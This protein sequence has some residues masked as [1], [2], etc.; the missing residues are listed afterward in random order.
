M[1]ITGLIPEPQSTSNEWAERCGYWQRKSDERPNKRKRREKETRGLILAGHGISIAVHRGTLLIQDGNTHF[2]SQK[3]THRLFKGDLNNPPRIVL[4]DGSGNV[5]L[6]AIDWLA[7]QKVDL[8]RLKWDGRISSVASASG[9]S[10]NP[11]R[12]A[13]QLATRQNASKRMTFAVGQ[14]T[15]KI[16]G[17]LF[18]LENLLPPS[19]SR[20]KAI[21]TAKSALKELKNR[22]PQSIGKLLAIEGAV[23]AGYFF[24][25]RAISL[26]WKSTTRYPIPDEWRRYFSRSSLKHLKTPGN[27]A[28]THPIN[29]MLNYAY[30]ILEA[31]VRM[32][33][34]A[35]GYDPSIGILHDRISPDRHSF[36]FDLIEPLRPPIDRIIL[37]LITL[38]E[39][40]G[41]D[42]I[43][44]RHGV[45][46]L[47]PNLAR[48]I[49]RECEKQEYSLTEIGKP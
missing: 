33:T 27:S 44:Q 45:C 9:Y 10:A 35:Q 42:F 37:K 32:Q 40:C 15:D 39:F 12:L 38:E 36:V 7:E 1:D 31:Q 21:E 48:K 34:I 6:D 3:R 20:E 47:M 49:V 24:A 28:A 19:H 43:L 4:V 30:G 11:K 5:T 13:W 2:P 41:N 29:A 23:A 46:R 25:W 18:N 17:T 26:N 22:K 16:R 8:I 14:I